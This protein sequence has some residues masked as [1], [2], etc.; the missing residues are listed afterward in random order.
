M[1]LK[2]DRW[3]G[4]G[5]TRFNNKLLN[6]KPTHEYYDWLRGPLVEHMIY[7]LTKT[8]G[9]S[10]FSPHNMLGGAARRWAWGWAAR[11]M[12]A[13]VAAVGPGETIRG[14]AWEGA[15]TVRAIAAAVGPGAAR[16]GAGG[17]GARTVRDTAAA[18][19]RGR[20]RGPGRAWPLGG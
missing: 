18:G 4:K 11:N 17:E 12:R 7:Y 5:S 14:A 10:R 19:A 2:F 13:A 20:S 6:Q 16:R 9:D 15:R 3:D 1:M 8:G